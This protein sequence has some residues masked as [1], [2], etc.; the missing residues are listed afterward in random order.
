[1]RDPVH[2]LAT[3]SFGL[4]WIAY[5]PFI[6]FGLAWLMLGGVIDVRRLTRW[7]GCVVIVAVTGVLLALY[8]SGERCCG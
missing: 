7:S 3:A 6:S 5:P 4:L 2:A 8:L 1:M